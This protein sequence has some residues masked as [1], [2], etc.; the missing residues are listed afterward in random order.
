MTWD[1]LQ[2]DEKRLWRSEVFTRAA[3]ARL[4]EECKSAQDATIA[5][6]SDTTLSLDEIR[7]QAG[8]AA[9]MDALIHI[10]EDS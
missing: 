3:F 9:G 10:L 2:P 7:F 6:A 4:H 5:N 8:V 1:Q